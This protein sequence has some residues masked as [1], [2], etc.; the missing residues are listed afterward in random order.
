VAGP[1]GPTGPTGATG[2]LAYTAENTANRG[3]AN[4]YA[5]LDAS[6]LVPA[7][8]LPSYIDDVLEYANSA[9]FPA[10][11]ETGKIYVAADT[12]RSW[13]W[14]GSVYAEII[15]S[16]GTT[17]AVTEGTTNLYYTATR[18]DGRITAAIGTSVQAYSSTLTTW[19]S[20]TAPTGDVVGTSDTQT[21][22]NKTLTSPTL[23]T[24]ALGTPSS[25]T[26]TNATGL[27]VSGISATGTASSSTYL[28]G[29]GS[30]QTVAATGET[31]NPFLLMGA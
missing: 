25:G 5:P 30:W 20:K 18:A 23:T 11:G 6:A 27:P 19:A 2:S 22:T 24:P 4:G 9:A 10:T 15:A 13:R 31:V 1:T 21:L 8:S 7:S 26:L 17:D 16:P 29:D 28:R 3:V 14:T 12:S